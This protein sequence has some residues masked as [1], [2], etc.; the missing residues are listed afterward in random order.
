MKRAICFFLALLLLLALSAC[1]EEKE[2]ASPYVG[3]WTAAAARYGDVF[4]DIYEVYSDG[5]ILEL[6]D[7]GV[8][9]LTL[10]EASS[11]ATWSEVNGAITISDGE[12]DLVGTIDENA[13]VLEISGM[14]ITLLREG[15]SAEAGQEEAQPAPEESPDE[16]A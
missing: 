11:P 7:N 1:G 2:S 12:T 16:A 6:Q 9:L 3:V 10:G 14:Y 15:A 8:C 4:I 13:I 5:M